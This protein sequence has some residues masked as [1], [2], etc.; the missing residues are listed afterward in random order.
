MPAAIVGSVLAAVYELFRAGRVVE[1]SIAFDR[2]V[3]F[4]AWSMQSIDLG[5]WCA[6]ESLV[7]AGVLTSATM[8]EPAALPDEVMR[9][10]FARLL[11]AA[12]LSS[13]E[14]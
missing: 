8:R 14:R 11:E 3:P 1:A 5:V 10:E 2:I 4:V 13:G 12:D 7:L 9:A 6:K